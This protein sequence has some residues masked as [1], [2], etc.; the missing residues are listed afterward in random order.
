MSTSSNK[1][2][3]KHS[4]SGLHSCKD[5][6]LTA[7][8][9]TLLSKLRSGEIKPFVN[10]YQRKNGFTEHTQLKLRTGQGPKSTLWLGI[11]H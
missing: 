2:L 10:N 6:A 7:F 8:S 3:E 4:I 1:V 5:R 9:E 11:T